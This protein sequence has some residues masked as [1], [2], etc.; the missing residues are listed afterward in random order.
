MPI[1]RRALLSV[2]APQALAS[3]LA[4]S[5]ASALSR[6]SHRGL[7]LGRRVAGRARHE[8]PQPPVRRVVSRTDAFADVLS[9]RVLG[10]LRMDAPRRGSREVVINA[11]DLA[12]GS[13][14]RF[15]NRESGTWRHGAVVGNSVPLAT[16]VAASAAYPRALPALDREWLF[17]RRSG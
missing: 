4:A 12:T 13:A 15:G 3:R 9:D 10:N 6:A 1:A 8:L 16:A 14:F 17:E 2:R 7:N 5:G 11:C